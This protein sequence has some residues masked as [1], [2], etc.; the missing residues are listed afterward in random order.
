[1]LAPEKVKTYRGFA[2]ERSADKAPISSRLRAGG[3]RGIRTVETLFG[4][5]IAPLPTR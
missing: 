4:R 1:M 5:K 3:A 2:P